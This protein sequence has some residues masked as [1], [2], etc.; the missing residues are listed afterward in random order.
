MTKSFTIRTYLIFAYI[1]TIFLVLAVLSIGIHISRTE[2]KHKI[3]VQFDGFNSNKSSIYQYINMTYPEEIIHYPIFEQ[4][5][6]IKLC[7]NYHYSIEF[8][9]FVAILSTF[10]DTLLPFV[11]YGLPIAPFIIM[12]ITSIVIFCINFTS[13]IVIIMILEISLILTGYIIIFIRCTIP[14]LDDNIVNCWLKVKRLY[15]SDTNES[16]DDKF[17][18]KHDIYSD[19]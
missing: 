15:V 19:C 13:D 3:N 12:C 9:K 1:N 4:F 5:S 16:I 17:Y 2:E 11:L 14:K 6:K 18:I 8:G 7:E 10:Y